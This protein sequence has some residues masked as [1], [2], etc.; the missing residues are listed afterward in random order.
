M[1]ELHSE[2]DVNFPTVTSKLQ[3]VCI[4]CDAQVLGHV[5]S[6]EGIVRVL[7]APCENC[8]EDFNDY[9]T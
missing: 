5:E 8:T 4:R 1:D 9:D 7:V 2:W 3:L 6:K